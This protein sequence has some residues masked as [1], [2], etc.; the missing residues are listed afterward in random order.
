M[1][2]ELR[3]LRSDNFTYLMILD[4]ESRHGIHASGEETMTHFADPGSPV[5][6]FCDRNLQRL[7]ETQGV[8]L[9]SLNGLPAKP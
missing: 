3:T 6:Q 9:Y 2:D 5:R 8:V 4:L 7:F 1:D